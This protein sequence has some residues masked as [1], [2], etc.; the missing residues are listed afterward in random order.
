MKLNQYF[1]KESTFFIIYFI[2]F[3]LFYL[4]Y[5][6]LG[7]NMPI[8]IHDNL[9]SNVVWAKLIL[10]NNVV[11]GAPDAP[12][13]Q[14]LSGM[15]RGNVYGTYDFSIVLFSIFGM[16]WGIVVNKMLISL[17]AFFGMYLLLKHHFTQN[18]KDL[19][20]AFGVACVYSFLPFWS[21]SVS[22]AGLPFLVYAFLNIRN[23]NKLGYNWLIFVLYPLYSSLV[24]VGFFILVLFTFVFIYDLYKS[25]QQKWTILLGISLIS[26]VYIVSHFALFYNFIFLDD[27]ISHREE[28]VFGNLSNFNG[29]SVRSIKIFLF[30][31]THSESFQLL[32]AL[33]ALF[34]VF[35]LIIK[36]HIKLLILSILCF[37]V[38]TS[39]FYG[40]YGSTFLL[41]LKEFIT[42]LLP[43]QFDRFYMLNP[44]LWYILFFVLLIFITEKINFQ[45]ALL[46]LIVQFFYVLSSHDIIYNKNPGFGEF[47]SSKKFEKIK[48]F[49]DEPTK[50]FRV[51]GLGFEPA[52]L[53]YN[54]FYTLDGYFPD[55]PLSYKHQFRKIIE[56]E[57]QKDT[58]LQKYFDNWGSRCYAFSAELG[59]PN[60][61]DFYKSYEIDDLEFN[62]EAFK[63][64]GGKYILSIAKINGIN[65]NLELMKIFENE[66][67][68][69][70]IY[71][72]K[73]N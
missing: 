72:Y 69:P 10:D 63:N 43:M 45:F 19:F 71:L 36:R 14:A 1:Y 56:R 22:V 52:V 70:R 64:L 18:K 62:L 20:F 35:Y 27:Y 55:Y 3:L 42:N 60:G 29:A 68:Y 13:P 44:F 38:S 59:R 39:L 5:F 31:Q 17:I 12:I 67:I 47:Y 66:G 53:L 34:I 40:F 48:D 16:F 54:G 11:F 24:V 46:I 25:R 30:G 41:P 50:S 73:V 4:P 15:V 32:I 7:E 51:I 57:L 37:L 28:F 21:Y 65:D 6:V 61:L 26:A 33:S 8:R 23:G 2:I 9:D 58:G 49:I